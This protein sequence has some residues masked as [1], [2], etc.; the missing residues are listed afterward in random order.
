MRYAIVLYYQVAEGGIKNVILDAESG[1]GC[2]EQLTITG[3]YGEFSKN[4]LFFATDYNNNVYSTKD[5]SVVYTATD[6][7]ARCFSVDGGWLVVAKNNPVTVLNIVE[8]ETWTLIKNLSSTNLGTQ[9]SPVLAISPNKLWVAMGH[10][11]GFMVWN[12]TTLNEIVIS[13]PFATGTAITD[14]TFSP[15]N[16]YLAVSAD[17]LISN[18]VPFAIFDTI[19]WERIETSSLYTSDAGWVECLR[20]TPD[21]QYLILGSYIYVASGQSYFLDGLAILQTSN[22]QWLNNFEKM[23]DMVTSIDFHPTLP[24]ML[25]TKSN[26]TTIPPYVV[27][28]MTDWTLIKSG[29]NAQYYD[30]KTVDATVYLQPIEMSGVRAI[31][32]PFPLLKSLSGVVYDITG[33]PLSTTVSVLDRVSGLSERSIISSVDGQYQFLYLNDSTNKVFVAIS[34]DST[35]EMIIDAG[36]PA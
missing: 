12:T 19:T 24:Y 10:L 7:R 34:Q 18:T 25:L 6:S 16:R 21:G 14:I 29:M 1:E 3:S 9:T 15:D 28:D 4:G 36:H 5:W 2:I 8:T 30:D 35:N 23:T 17:Y 32:S 20:F 26:D 11:T 31:Y 33:S 22:W 13:S 27:Y